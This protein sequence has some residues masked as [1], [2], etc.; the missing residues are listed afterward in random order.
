MTKRI[1]LITSIAG[2]GHL[3]AAQ[4]KAAEHDRDE[5]IRI[6]IFEDTMGPVGNFCSWMWNNAQR[7]GNFRRQK[8]LTRQQPLADFFFWI[9][10]FLRVFRILVRNDIDKIVDTQPVGTS[11]II[12]AIKWARHITKKNLILEKILTELPSSHIPHYFVPITTMSKSDRRLISFETVPPMK[13]DELF[14]KNR[15]GLSS[16][17]IITRP[18]LLRKAFL[19]V[20]KEKP[21]ITSVTIATPTGEATIPIPPQA[22]VSTIMLGSNPPEK[23]TVSYIQTFIETKKVCPDG[24]DMLFVFAN[25]LSLFE[26]IDAFEKVPG[27]QVIPLVFQ[28]DTVIA[29]LF[30]RSNATLTKSGGLTS[31]ELLALAQ[32]KIWIHSESKKNRAPLD[33]MPI[34]EAGNASYLAKAKNA[35]CVTPDTFDTIATTLFKKS[36]A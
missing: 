27:L 13:D 26:R 34:W 21:M 6:D 11:A 17:Q 14:W 7:K 28:K 33:G 12:K 16:Y 36:S 29:P 8:W 1:L 10:I 25:R 3:Q 5:I 31:M 20:L 18:P 15:Y 4:I 19:D 30:Y 9:P 23:A 24:D 22:R 32:G 35:Q 2:G